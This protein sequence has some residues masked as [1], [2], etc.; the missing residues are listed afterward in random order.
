MYKQYIE[1]RLELPRRH[2]ADFVD[3]EYD[4]T[5]IARYDELIKLY[6]YVNNNL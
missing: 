2:I 4:E 6:Y 1:E 3:D 5:I